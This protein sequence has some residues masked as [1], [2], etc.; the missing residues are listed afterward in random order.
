MTTGIRGRAE[1]DRVS[2][3]LLASITDKSDEGHY[4][5]DR[6]S[7]LEWAARRPVSRLA[8]R[9]LDCRGWTVF[10]MKRE[11]RVSARAAVLARVLEWLDLVVSRLSSGARMKGSYLRFTPQNLTGG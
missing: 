3:R 10:L 4:L 2:R 5:P 8:N 7:P 6:L 1:L 9:A 11:R